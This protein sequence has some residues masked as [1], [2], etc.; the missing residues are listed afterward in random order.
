MLERD[1]THADAMLMEAQAL[2]ARRHMSYHA[3]SSARGM[4]RFQENRLDEAV[5]L[6]KE[7]R[8]LA[9]SSGD[10]ISEFQ[11]N[12][13]LAIVIT[14]YSIHYT[15][16]YEAMLEELAAGTQAP[17]EAEAVRRVFACVISECRRLQERQQESG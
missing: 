13:Y 14:S 11:A 7:A 17:L 16:L 4:L 3:I 8:T 15:K 5:E 1:L 9:R 6:F 2:A 12:E 10:R